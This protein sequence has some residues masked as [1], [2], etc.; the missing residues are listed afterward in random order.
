MNE[1]GGGAPCAPGKR[2]DNKRVLSAVGLYRRLLDAQRIR[3]PGHVLILSRRLV[4]RLD[5]MTYREQRAYYRQI[6]AMRREQP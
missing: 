1:L 3:R 5:V 4:H 2:H 6:A